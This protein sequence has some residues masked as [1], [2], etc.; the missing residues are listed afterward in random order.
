MKDVM[1]LLSVNYADGRH[2][3]FEFDIAS[4]GVEELFY[5]YY[6]AREQQGYQ[7][8]SLFIASGKSFVPMLLWTKGGKLVN[9]I[10][11]VS[12]IE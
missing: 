3:T 2:F 10:A 7:A 8:L 11:P 4:N 1:Y 9:N 12:I 5:N 6:N